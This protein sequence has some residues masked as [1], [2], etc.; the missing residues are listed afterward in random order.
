MKKLTFIILL[1]T[2]HCLLFTINCSAQPITFA[3][4]Y[5][6]STDLQGY[7][8]VATYDNNYIIAGEKDNVPYVFKLDSA[9]NILW[10][11]K[12]GNDINTSFNC[13]ISTKDSCY[14]LAG[15][16]INSTNSTFDTYYVKINSNGDTIWS[17][18]IDLGSDEYTYSIQQTYDNGYIIAGQ[19]DQSV[20]PYSKIFIIKI[21]SIG[22]ITWTKILG[23]N[24]Y[25]YAY[26]VRQTSDNGYLMMG[27]IQNTTDE[28]TCL[29]KLSSSG[30]ISWSKENI[31]SSGCDVIVNAN[32]LICL[33]ADFSSGGDIISKIDFSGNVIWSKNFSVAST[34]FGYNYPVHRLIK[35]SDGG[36]VF[37]TTGQWG[38]QGVQ[39]IKIDSLAN[40]IWSEDLLLNASDIKESNDRGLIV[41]GNG[42]LQGVKMNK[43]INQH[44]GIIKM[45]SLGNSIEC[46]QQQMII[47]NTTTVS[48][49]PV[50][51]TSNTGSVF[52][53]L[54]P[55]V[56]NSTLSGINGCVGIEGGVEENPTDENV[57][58]V[59][60]N[61]T[62]DH[63]ILK[64]S[65]NTK[66]TIKIYNLLG[67]IKYTS[68][69]SSPETT[70]DIADLAKG[71]Y[72]VEVATEK[73]IM[74][75][76]FVKE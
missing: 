3:K 44:I 48:F 32:G 49:T 22:N 58:Q 5:I 4:V 67:E 56:S 42:P 14:L 66:A 41:L 18:S 76:K 40:L 35:T 46:V 23:G 63:I 52:N 68:I 15:Q 2:V 28:G 61:P 12:I 7:A 16:S 26:S 43:N 69:M 20:V 65:Q 39:L 38:A 6:A 47:S 8:I 33:M 45:D 34:G 9:G 21:D 54:H 50:I 51:F 62:S 11:K 30:N 10:N 25:N 64:F 27:Y 70:I 74:R 24:E 17:K 55:L 36:Y 53:I 31:N 57:L 13:I 75:K 37:V 1:L 29:I 19:T 59:F 71:V 72:I 60:P 73:K